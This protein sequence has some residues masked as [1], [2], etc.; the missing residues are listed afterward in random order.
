MEAVSG[1]TFFACPWFPKKKDAESGGVQKWKPRL[2]VIWARVGVALTT[3]EK[4]P[5]AKCQ[6]TTLKRRHAV[7]IVRTNA[8]HTLSA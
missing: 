2:L 7:K 5:P 8:H 1:M 4:G 3:T 6:R